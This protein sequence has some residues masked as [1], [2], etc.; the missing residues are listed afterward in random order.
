MAS[1][2]SLGLNG[3]VVELRIKVL[4]SSKGQTAGHVEAVDRAC[5]E[6]L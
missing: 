6:A 5:R 4:L 1:V 3:E 2:A